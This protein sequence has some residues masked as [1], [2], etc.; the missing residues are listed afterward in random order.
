MPPAPAL[1]RLLQMNPND[2]ESLFL[3]GLLVSGTPWK[4][5]QEKLAVYRQVYLIALVTPVISIAGVVLA[6]FIKRREV[7]KLVA[8]G[9]T[10]SEAKKTLEQHDETPAPN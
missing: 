2:V 4:T 9:M 7:A 3:K 6:Y 8:T 10:A 5:Q 1:E